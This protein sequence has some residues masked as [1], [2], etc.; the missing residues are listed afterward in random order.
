[1]SVVGVGLL[2]PKRETN[3][4]SAYRSCHIFDV[5]LIELIGARFTY[6]ASDT[7]R[8]YRNIPLIVTN[9]LIIPYDCIPIAVEI[10]EDAIPLPKFN[11]PRNAFYIFG[12][13]DG[14]VPDK[15]LGGCR[16]TITIPG[17]FCL[18]LAC[19]VT[20]VLYDRASKQDTY[21]M[22]VI[23]NYNKFNLDEALKTLAEETRRPGKAFREPGPSPY[24]LSA[25][26]KK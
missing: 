17:Q 7:T 8:A 6:Q 22:P 14:S 24:D 4:G 13:E 9:D 15:I 20:A 5:D 3:V 11:H 23:K 2:Y 19:A 1:M 18:N 16:W 12:P 26:R 10:T 21:T 25:R